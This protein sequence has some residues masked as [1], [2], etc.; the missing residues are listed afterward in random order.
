[1]ADYVIT[2]ATSGIGLATKQTLEKQ[3]HRVFN[4]D[5]KDGDFTA[6]DDLVIQV[7]GTG[8]GISASDFN[9]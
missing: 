1:M 2:G 9:I 6:A 7:V 3:G 4:V 8:L 5:Y